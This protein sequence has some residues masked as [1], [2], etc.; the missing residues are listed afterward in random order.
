MYSLLMALLARGVY[1]S[2]RGLVCRICLEMCAEKMRKVCVPGW[3]VGV[4]TTCVNRTMWLGV[5]ASVWACGSEEECGMLVE[6]K[7]SSLH[8]KEMIVSA[9]NYSPASLLV[10]QRG[11]RLLMV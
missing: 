3:C 6:A 1:V 8:M 9:A 11:H 10:L 2:V 5:C 7:W 4:P